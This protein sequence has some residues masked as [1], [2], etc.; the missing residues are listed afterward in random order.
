V[1]FLP[2]EISLSYI[3][4]FFNTKKILGHGANPLLPLRRKTCSGFLSPLT[5]GPMASTLTTRTRSTTCFL[6]SLFYL[7]IALV[8][9]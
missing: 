5:L 2:Y 3:E 1:M 9:Y 6:I 7:S 8:T 4:G